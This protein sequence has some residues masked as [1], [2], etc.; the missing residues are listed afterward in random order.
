MTVSFAEAADRPPT[1]FLR[2]CGQIDRRRTFLRGGGGRIDCASAAASTGTRPGS[3]ARRAPELANG[4]RRLRRLDVRRLRALGALGD[5]EG[6]PLVLVKT[7]V[8]VRR[9]RREVR[10]HVRA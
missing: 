10:E 6:H 4:A 1:Y 9:D 3:Q 7:P 2:G 8:A 5:L